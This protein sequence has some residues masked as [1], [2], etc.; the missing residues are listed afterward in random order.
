M[1]K[2]VEWG[3][4]LVILLLASS[5]IVPA[6]AVDQLVITISPDPPIQ[7]QAVTVTVTAAGVP[8][9]GVFIQFSMSGGTPIYAMT[10]S[11]GQAVFKT[12]LTGTLQIIATKSGYIATTTSASV[13]V[14]PTPTPTPTPTRRPGGGGGGGV[15]VPP[16]PTPALT[17]E[18]TPPP[19]PAPR[20]IPTRPVLVPAP[21]PT[22]PAP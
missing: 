21:T 9:S 18:P 8:V 7:G 22:P 3:I 13:V 2:R 5:V 6:S 17:P 10:D 4:V 1:N 15:Y 14:A 16:P 11:N 12:S 19:T 20:P